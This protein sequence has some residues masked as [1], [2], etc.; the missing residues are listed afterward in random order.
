MRTTK[1]TTNPRPPA[2]G[3][4][5]RRTKSARGTALLA[6]L[7]LSAALG[8][9]AIALAD[10]VRGEA[11]RSAT[12]VDG[13][14]AQNLAVGG[15]RRAI[16]YMD[17]GRR[18]PDVPRFKPPVPYFAFDFPEGQTVV[19][20]IP[21]D[22]KFNINRITIE[23]LF[24]LLIN[25]GAG[26]ARSQELAAAIMDWRSPAPDG[27][28]A[29]DEFYLSLR[30]PY[31]APHADFQEIEELLSVKGVTPDLF[32]GA[33][34]PTP[35]GAPQHL[36]P[37][38]GLRDCFSVFG[39]NSQFDVNTAAPAVL[40]TIG[41]PPAGVA[42]LVRQRSVQPFVIPDDLAP[43]A[44]IAGPGFGRLRIGGNTIFTLRSTARLRLVNGQLSDMRRTV[45][46]L[47]KL[48]PANYQASYHILRW[49]ETATAGQ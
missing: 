17:W 44:Q 7:W 22:A 3:P 4:R 45:A 33:W 23:D 27:P 28:S 32:Y 40:A 47:V 5:P 29:F 41:V 11:E 12:A 31:R 2:P 36:A 42:A 18:Y 16:L 25:L 1:W 21:E 39:Y 13:L 14:R 20:I 34:Q 8:A 49:Y 9:I 38:T 24:H 48:M 46:A 35:E 43:F 37:R 10:T 19:D 30:P 15:L 6:V 26:E